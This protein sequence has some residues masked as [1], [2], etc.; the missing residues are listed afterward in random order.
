MIYCQVKEEEVEQVK[1]V[2]DEEEENVPRRFLTVCMVCGCHVGSGAAI[3][4]GV[5]R[6]VGE[7]GQRPH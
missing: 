4:D 7:V 5:G 2:E 3:D 1:E 6:Q